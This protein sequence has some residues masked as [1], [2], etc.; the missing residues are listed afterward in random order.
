MFSALFL[1]HLLVL[2]EES[3]LPASANGRRAVILL[4]QYSGVFHA[5]RL[6]V[7]DKLGPKLVDLLVG[8]IGETDGRFASFSSFE[9]AVEEQV[10]GKLRH[11]SHLV[12]KRN[13]LV[14][15]SFV[16]SSFKTFK[17]T[18]HLRSDPHQ[19]LLTP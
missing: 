7:L 18:N 1:G 4:R 13:Q 9:I 2:G 10:F 8:D 3:R 16:P 17:E 11:L 14:R 5:F 6:E 19:T 15:W 12:M